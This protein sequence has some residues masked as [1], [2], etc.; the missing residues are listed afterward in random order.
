MLAGLIVSPSSGAGGAA[1]VAAGLVAFPAPA[2]CTR[3]KVPLIG[4]PSARGNRNVP[5][6]AAPST[7]TSVACPSGCARRRVL[8]KLPPSNC[9]LSAT[10]S[11]RR[12]GSA[13]PLPPVVNAIQSIASSVGVRP[14]ATSPEAGAA[15]ATR[16]LPNATRT[17]V[18]PLL[19][20]A[21]SAMR[22]PNATVMS[23]APSGSIVSTVVGNVAAA[24]LSS[25][26]GNAS[27]VPTRPDCRRNRVGGAASVAAPAADF[28]ID[29]ATVHG[30][31]PVTCGS[32]HAMSGA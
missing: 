5:A 20:R 13:C 8:A 31:R 30:E 24:G 1:A 21:R 14:V 15:S 27:R 17:P 16:P 4:A 18:C 22:W 10:T 9:N 2:Q 23:P 11:M 6:R 3:E 7:W 26:A 29:T 19:L 28:A 12:S 25:G 32:S